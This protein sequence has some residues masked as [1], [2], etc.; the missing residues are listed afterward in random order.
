MSN[1]EKKVLE[2]NGEYFVIHKGTIVNYFFTS[3]LVIA[4]GLFITL[5]IGGIIKMIEQSSKVINPNLIT[6]YQDD[7]LNIHYPIPGGNW[8]L[9]EY[10]DTEIVKAVED[11]W[12]TDKYFSI[13]DDI[14]VEEVISMLAVNETNPDATESGDEVGGIR[15]F[16]SF[17]F[18]PDMGYTGDSFVGFCEASFKNSIEKSGDISSYQLYSTEVDEYNGVMMK[19][20]VY[21]KVV[22]DD[23]ESLEE[24]YYI[25]YIRRIGKNLGVITYGSLI[26][27]K[28][29]EPYLQYFLANVVTEK[30]LLD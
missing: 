20:V 23:K 10:D 17:T 6:Y 28:T 11:S 13:E 4:L 3:V 18:M 29:V 25:Q 12:G 1:N 22:I 14:L 15:E 9:V 27:D 19:M 5:L 24:T 8:A 16:M 21:Q 30:S 26:E 7:V 2:N